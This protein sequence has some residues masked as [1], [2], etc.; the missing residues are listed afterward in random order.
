MLNLPERTA[1]SYKLYALSHRGNPSLKPVFA[2][3]FKPLCFSPVFT[4]GLQLKAYS[5]Q[6]F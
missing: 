3:S 2:F 4:Y 1:V 5:L 6:L